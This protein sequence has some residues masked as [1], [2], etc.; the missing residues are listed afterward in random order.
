MGTGPGTLLVAVVAHTQSKTQMYSEDVQQAEDA[1]P[2][3]AAA[4]T[5]HTC[6]VLCAR[7]SL[8]AA[9]VER[10]RC[11]LDA[12]TADNEALHVAA[13][14][15]GVVLCCTERTR[16]LHVCRIDADGT[17]RRVVSLDVGFRVLAMTGS[18]KL[19]DPD[20]QLL[21]VSELVSSSA[22]A[23]S[24]G[25]RSS[26]AGNGGVHVLR[27]VVESTE[28]ARHEQ[29]ALLKTRGQR[30]V[31][32]DDLL[33]TAAWND[34]VKRFDVEARRVAPGGRSGQKL[35]FPAG[36]NVQLNVDAWAA[37]LGALVIYDATQEALVLLHLISD[38]SDY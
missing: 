16:A 27:L 38:D 3:A 33:L 15:S 12:A 30:L 7:D 22:V 20:E 6:L 32:A 37:D 25:R 10:Q 13:L 24:A 26:R 1:G 14:D 34:E 19:S 36:D 29:I 21:F 2:S 5:L 11:V 18:E 35:D 17:L 28:W 8:K 23:K 4:D 31:L 9:W